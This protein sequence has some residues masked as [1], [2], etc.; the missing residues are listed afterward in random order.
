[1]EPS[2]YLSGIGLFS[3][4]EVYFVLFIWTEIYEDNMATCYAVLFLKVQVMSLLF[5]IILT[6]SVSEKEV[7][8][9][10]RARG[11]FQCS[12]FGDHEVSLAINTLHQF[13]VVVNNYLQ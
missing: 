9:K 5:Y 11:L 12:L 4:I 7:P 1:M 13:P 6:A 2:G 3:S 8:H 10:L